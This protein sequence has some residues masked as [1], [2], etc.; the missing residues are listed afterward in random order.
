MFIHILIGAGKI[1]LFLFLGY[2]FLFSNDF[3]TLEDIVQK[4]A[5]K[6]FEKPYKEKFEFLEQFE[7]KKFFIVDIRDYCNGNFS[8]WVGTYN[9]KYI[10]TG[11][12][13][14]YGVPFKILSEE[15]SKYTCVMTKSE[16]LDGHLNFSIPL[17]KKVYAIY[18]LIANYYAGP[19]E[20][21]ERK[22]IFKYEDG[23]SEDL[24]LIYGINMF[25][26]WPQERKETEDLK[27]IL[28][29]SSE[30][31]LPPFRNLYILQ[32]KNPNI[33]K[34]IKEIEFYSDGKGM[35]AVIVIGITVLLNE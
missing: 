28:V 20:K 25:D 24:Q 19:E 31:F 17:R 5:K 1:I 34:T 16:I 14:Y 12:K 6:L 3:D 13:N 22:F 7:K 29:R 15:E 21:G 27:Y 9:L 32:W 23:K 26:W 8:K 10:E 33:D 2:N 30:S 11:D 4:A 35:R 18:F